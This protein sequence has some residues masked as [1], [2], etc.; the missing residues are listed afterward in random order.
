MK[1]M[2][3]IAPRASNAPDLKEILFRSQPAQQIVK[4]VVTFRPAPANTDAL[5]AAQER[6]AAG[7]SIFVQSTFGSTADQRE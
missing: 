7:K 2:F 4:E 3:S 1:S 5:R 6:Q